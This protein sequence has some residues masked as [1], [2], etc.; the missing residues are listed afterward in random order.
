MIIRQTL[1]LLPMCCHTLFDRA[2][3]TG[4]FVQSHIIIWIPSFLC[5][6][7]MFF[8]ETINVFAFRC[9]DCFSSPHINRFA[10]VFAWQLGDGYSSEELSIGLPQPQVLSCFLPQG[11]PRV[12]AKVCTKLTPLPSVSE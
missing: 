2:L 7:S 4:D 3:S 8:L 6:V 10:P 9:K 12:V 5:L 1:P 11:M